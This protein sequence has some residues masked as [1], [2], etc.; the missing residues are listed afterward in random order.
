MIGRAKIE[1]SPAPGAGG[2]ETFDLL[3]MRHVF[4]GCVPSW[5]HT[6][7]K[8]SLDLGLVVVGLALS[9]LYYN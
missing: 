7:T 6:R 3:V 5:R 1:Q 4:Y 9:I 8:E 2:I